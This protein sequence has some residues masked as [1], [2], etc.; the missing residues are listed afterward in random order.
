[1]IIIIDELIKKMKALALQIII[2]S[3]II[4]NQI[5]VSFFQKFCDASASA[6]LKIIR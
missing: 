4:I 5:R 3:E 6:F 2:M 1:M